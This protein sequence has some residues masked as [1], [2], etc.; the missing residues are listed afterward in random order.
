MDR[1]PDVYTFLMFIQI[2]SK[3]EGKSK[4]NGKGEVFI[5]IISKSKGK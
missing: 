3:S 2:F 5:F 4:I 1:K